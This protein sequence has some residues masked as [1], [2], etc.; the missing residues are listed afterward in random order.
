L[1]VAT[2]VGKILPVNLVVFAMFDYDVILGM[3]WLTKH[4]ANIDYARKR[5]TL[6]PWGDIEITFVG[7]RA[8]TILPVRLAVQA[9]KFIASGDS[10]FVAFVI[11]TIKKKEEKNLQDIPM[12]QEFPDVFSTEFSS[13]PPERE[14]KFGI[15]CISG[16]RPISKAPYQMEPAELKELK[17]QL[18]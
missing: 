16:T 14:V 11:E 3:D 4:H 1:A 9:R 7:S 6:R 2:P 8:N 5:V 12:V 13:L 17:V 15:E 10:V 18:Q